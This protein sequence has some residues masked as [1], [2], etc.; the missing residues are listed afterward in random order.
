MTYEQQLAQL[1]NLIQQLENAELTLEASLTAYE[2]G[3]A[4]IRD[5]QKKLEH[6]EQ[7]IRQLSHDKNGH[8]VLVPFNTEDDRLNPALSETDNAERSS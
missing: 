8:E 6:A 3:V 5:C 1:E 2:Q 4:L 7:R